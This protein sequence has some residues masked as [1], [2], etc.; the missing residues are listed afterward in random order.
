ME[1]DPNPFPEI[2][3]VGMPPMPGIARAI[4]KAL[5]RPEALLSSSEHY[6]RE[7]FTDEPVTPAEG[8]PP[9]TKWE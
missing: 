8:L 6:V 1:A 7:H 5:G 9:A 4:A 2:S 3:I